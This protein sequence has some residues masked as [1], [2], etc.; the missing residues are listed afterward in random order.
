MT[1][2]AHNTTD[3]LR[4]IIAQGRIS[5]D[6]LHAITGIG[7]EKL[8]P[9]L[10]EAQPE[11]TGLTTQPQALSDEESVRLS[12]LAAQLTDGLQID[13]DERLK[14][15]FESLTVECGLTLQN[16]A[17]FIGLDAG[18]VESALG[19]PQSI[20][21]DTKYQLAIRGSYLINAANRARG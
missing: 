6:A 15:I 20:P 19:A 7:R 21:A 1:S 13:D 14:A 10:Y 4:Q 18:D 12:V 11:V 5:E 16:I 17:E 2:Q 8:R 9:L 3:E